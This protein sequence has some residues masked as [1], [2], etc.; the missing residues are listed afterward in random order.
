MSEAYTGGDSKHGN[1]SFVA[2]V[3]VVVAGLTISSIFS[4]GGKSECQCGAMKAK[5]GAP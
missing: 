3:A 2:F 5:A 4:G 1:W